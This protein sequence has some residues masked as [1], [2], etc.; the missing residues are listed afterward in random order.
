[1]SEQSFR[2]EQ[3]IAWSFHRNTSRWPF[4]VVEPEESS[5]LQLPPKE[6]PEA[7]YLALPPPRAPDA[8]L[9]SVLRG[10]YSCRQFD[11]VALGRAALNLMKTFA[12]G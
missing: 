9:E 1:M 7:P 3:P 2:D 10:R 8:P 12:G 5:E 11:D 4:N 6:Y